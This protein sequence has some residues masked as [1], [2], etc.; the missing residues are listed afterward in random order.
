MQSRRPP[1]SHSTHSSS[2]PFTVS[3]QRQL[4]AE[5]TATPSVAAV[6][7]STTS[8]SSA[9]ASDSGCVKMGASL[10]LRRFTDIRPEDEFRC[11]VRGGAPGCG[12]PA[13]R[14]TTLPAA[15]APQH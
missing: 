4:P 15:G 10:T 8:A 1:S 7:A 11:F 12:L 6:P 3:C 9:A 13:G 2:S 14:F 5:G